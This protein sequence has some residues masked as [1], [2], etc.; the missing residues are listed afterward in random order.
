M[1]RNKNEIMKILLENKEKAN[2]Q[3]AHLHFT[4]A[5]AQTQNY[6]R[7]IFLPIHSLL[8]VHL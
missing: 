2:P 1:Q 7:A 5:Y 3:I 4:R 8:N 6:K